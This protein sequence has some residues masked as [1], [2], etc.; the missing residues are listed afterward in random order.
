MCIRDSGVSM[1]KAGDIYDLSRGMNEELNKQ[2]RENTEN[3][4]KEFVSKVAD[5]RGMEYTE[6]LKFA[7]GRIWRGDTALKLGLVDKLGSLDDAIES[8]VA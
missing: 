8:M 3:F 5:N 4:Y 6:V 2:F 7:G 1:T